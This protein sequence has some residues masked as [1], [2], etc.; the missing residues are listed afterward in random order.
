MEYIHKKKAENTRA[1]QLS[2]V[3]TILL[4]HVRCT[5]Y[6]WSQYYCWVYQIH[7]LLVT[8][9]TI[10]L[11]IS[12]IHV[13]GQVGTLYFVLENMSS[14]NKIV[15]CLLIALIRRAFYWLYYPTHSVWEGYCSRRVSQ[16]VC[17]FVT[18]GVTLNSLNC[19][20]ET[21]NFLQIFFVMSIFM[22]SCSG[23]SQLLRFQ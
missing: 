9:H 12:I 3:F 19:A 23:A 22:Q 5:I 7:V 16:L 8:I 18:H 1:K 6:R 2:Y 14:M 4:L 15:P 21:L 11:D 13:L 17:Q 20:S 10:L